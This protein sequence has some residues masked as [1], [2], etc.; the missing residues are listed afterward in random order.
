ML[1]GSAF[2]PGLAYAAARK[3]ATPTD[4]VAAQRITVTRAPT[5]QMFV[6]M[7]FDDG[8]H[9]RLT[10]QLLDMLKARRIRATFFLIGRNAARYPDLVKRI[11]DEGHEIG[12]HSW[13]HPYLSG[14]GTSSVLRQIDRTSEAIFRATNRM[15]VTMRPPYGALT[16]GQRS[17]LFRERGLPTILWSVDPQDWRR[18]GSSVV[19]SRILS[20]ARPG[21]I[22]LSHDIHSATVAAMPATLDGLTAAGYRFATISMILG[23]RDWNKLHWRLRPKPL[24]AKN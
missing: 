24:Q 21:S 15:P 10:P 5:R 12:N 17:M 8:P 18:P 4:I 20:H 1:A 13:S 9:P 14:L 6:A 19:A 22:V 7:T 3:S 2:A 11:A 16:Y 23:H